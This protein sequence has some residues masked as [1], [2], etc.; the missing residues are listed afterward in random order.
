MSINKVGPLAVL[1]L[2]ASGTAWGQVQTG[3][4]FNFI[5]PGARSLGM[6]GAFIGLADDATAAYTNPAGLTNLTIGGSEAAVEYRQ[7]NN[8][9]FFV[10]RGRLDETFAT[11]RGVDTINRLARGEAE[12]TTSGLSFLSYS[13]VLPH[14]FTLALYRH[15]LANYSSEQAKQGIFL[16]DRD[17]CIC[18]R[19]YP[20]LTAVDLRIANYG[21]S[22]AYAFELPAKDQDTGSAGSISVGLGLTLSELDLNYQSHFFGFN[23]RTGFD[24]IDRQPGGFF[25]PADFTPDNA[26]AAQIAQGKDH[27]Q[28]F[29]LGVLW[30]QGSG[31]SIEKHEEA[32]AR[33]RHH[34]RN[35]RWS[36][37]AVYRK[38]PSFQVDGSIREKNGAS[39]T[40]T[41]GL[42]VPDTYGL[43][44]AFSMGEGETK[45]TL[46]FDRIRWSQRF[47]E[48]IPQGVDDRSKFSLADANE[49]H[50]G[51]EQVVFVLEGQIIGTLRLGAWREPA[52]EV[53]Y[54]G[55]EP[56]NKVLFP[57][58]REITHWSAGV[59]IVLKE[60]Y[61]L[62]TALDLSDRAKTVSFSVVKFF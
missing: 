10:E 39:G 60:D 25:G 27:A 20:S 62:D 1:A 29:N 37:G 12:A 43:G 2:L 30:K 45:I 61:Q 53:E 23:A 58:G 3:P 6:G 9:T 46:D 28:G 54:Q 40:A 22:V 4:Q 7:F 59:G 34:L 52:H 47:D 18:D 24:W 35:G 8:T 19:S 11:G 48:I 44:V 51:L 21:A 32:P 17:T 42:R 15:Q 49:L 13:K 14:G 36:V 5:S 50:L 31:S 33:W 38:G 56:E 16:T 55:S 57:K 26:F 41:L